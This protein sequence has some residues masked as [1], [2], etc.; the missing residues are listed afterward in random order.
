M[1]WTTATDAR[2]ALDSSPIHFVA[3]DIAPWPRS[4]VAGP[5]F[6]TTSRCHIFRHSLLFRTDRHN[7]RSSPQPIG[8]GFTPYLRPVSNLGSTTVIAVNASPS[9]ADGLMDTRQKRKTPSVGART[10]PNEQG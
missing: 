9:I 3:D 10:R 5:A 6:I 2:S 1:V 4:K 7:C 8:S